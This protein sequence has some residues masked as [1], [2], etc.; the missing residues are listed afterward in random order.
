MAG[1]VK[2]PL[3]EYRGSRL[4]CKACG[5]EITPTARGEERDWEAH[6]GMQSH[7]V[8]A[9]RVH[10]STAK[11]PAEG[12][13]G[14][15]KRARKDDGPAEGL[16]AGFFDPAKAPAALREPSPPP[17]EKMDAEWAAFQSDIAAVAPAADAGVVAEAAPA[18]GGDAAPAPVADIEIEDEEDDVAAGLR[19]QFDEQ[20]ELEQRVERLKERR[21]ALRRRDA[22]QEPVGNGG[23]A[24]VAAGDRE[25][26]DG[27]DDDDDDDYDDLMWRSRKA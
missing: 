10:L 22:P 9:A 27:D 23:A 25:E 8:E 24:A 20:R 1:K 6:A 21:A 11:R 13:G 17:D 5:Y 26:S 15:G 3:A 19:Q 14:R 4:A 16:P 18:A 7:R 12:A 2:H